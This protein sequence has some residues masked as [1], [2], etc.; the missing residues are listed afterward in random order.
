MDKITR[1]RKLIIFGLVLVVIGVFIFIFLQ[2]GGN[3]K[4]IIINEN[5]VWKERIYIRQPDNL[6]AVCLGELFGITDLKQ[7]VYKIK[8]QTPLEWICVRNN[9]V[10]CIYKSNHLNNISVQTFLPKSLVAKDVYDLG[11]SEVTVTDEKI[12]KL[13]ISTLTDEYLVDT[14]VETSS[15]KKVVL[16]SDQYPG[17]CYTLYFS[18]NNDGNCYISD[19]YYQQ[20]WKT[21]PELMELIM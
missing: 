5:L 7:Q 18:H 15:M 11:G 1:K 3:E 12:I 19:D 20:I 17:L 10:E 13:L 9:G 4:F 14:A 8:G 21:G 6:E 16:I 2:K